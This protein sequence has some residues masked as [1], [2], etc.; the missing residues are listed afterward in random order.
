ME[1]QDR[2]KYPGKKPSK[3]G[4]TEENHKQKRALTSIDPTLLEMVERQTGRRSETVSS[5]RT[6]G[7]LF[8]GR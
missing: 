1:T 7:P 6:L 8:P 5:P 3:K 2:K 4:P